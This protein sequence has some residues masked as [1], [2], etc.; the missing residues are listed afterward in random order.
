MALRLADNWQSEALRARL[1]ARLS[2]MQIEDLWPDEA[3]WRQAASPSDE[4][5]RLAKN[6]LDAVPAELGPITASNVWAVSGSRSP[7]SRSTASATSCAA[8]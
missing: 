6:L 1:A 7:A 5:D 2:P 4:L 3:T 8:P